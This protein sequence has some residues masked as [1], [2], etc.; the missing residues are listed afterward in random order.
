MWPTSYSESN[1]AYMKWTLS[2]IVLVSI[3]NIQ[4]SFQ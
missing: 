4:V 1:K 2:Y 3:Q